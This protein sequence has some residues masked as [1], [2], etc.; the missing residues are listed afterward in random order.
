MK[1]ISISILLLIFSTNSLADEKRGKREV[2]LDNSDVEVVRLTYPAGAESGMHTHIHPNRVVYFVK[3][4]MLELI[5][6]DKKQKSKILKVS[7]GKTLFL[8]T[9]THNVKNIG[10]TEIIIIETEVKSR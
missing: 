1:Y 10:N 9:T 2:L 6:K 7:D 5:P 3:G 8:P 4:G